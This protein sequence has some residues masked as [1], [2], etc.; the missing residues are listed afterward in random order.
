ML[1]GSTELGRT[2]CNHRRILQHVFWAGLKN[3]FIDGTKTMFWQRVQ[4]SFGRSLEEGVL[5]PH[6][7][8]CP[9]NEQTTENS[10]EETPMM[11]RRWKWM[12]KKRIHLSELFACQRA[13]L[14]YNP[15]AQKWVDWW[16]ELHKQTRIESVVGTANH[17]C[18]RYCDMSGT[19]D[20]TLWLP[21]IPFDWG[22]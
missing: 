20:M 3:E 11:Y 7:Q 19:C 5:V 6:S 9:C 1:G 22:E 10:F 15:F 13:W 21:W 2:H 18:Q 4:K 14:T 17:H 12:P 8:K 16:D